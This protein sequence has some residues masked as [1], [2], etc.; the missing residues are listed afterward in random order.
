MF[1]TVH[2]MLYE[3][4]V[5]I[6]KPLDDR[7]RRFLDAVQ[8]SANRVVRFTGDDGWVRVTVEVAGMCR[9]DA[10]RAAAGEVARIFPASNDERYGEPQQR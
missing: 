9:E 3:V 1:A 8:A 10:L 2:S 6:A 7:T 5:T 4:D